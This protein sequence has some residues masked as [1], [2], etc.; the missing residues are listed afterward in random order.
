MRIGIDVDG[1][2]LDYEKG[3]MASA[4]IFDME[5]CRGEGR[6]YKDRYFIQDQYDWS[7]DEKKRFISEYLGNVSREAGI[8]PGAKVVL[9]KLRE[10][11][12]ELIIISA[13]GMESDELIDI[14]KE[15]FE[16]AG[17][18]FDKEFWKVTDKVGICKSEG[19]NVMIDD[20][21]ITCEKMAKNG[22]RSLYFRGIRGWELDDEIVEEV[23]SWGEVWRVIERIN[24]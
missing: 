5:M 23:L 21:P 7:D 16:S 9:E 12:H 11:G 20:S 19:V 3:M 8:M 14:V 13:R 17:M 24:I 10:M 22:I 6:K 4:E 18:W 2:L 15:K 1:V